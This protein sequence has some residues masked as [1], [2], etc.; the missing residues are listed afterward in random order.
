[1]SEIQ[2][3]GGIKM[4]AQEAAKRNEKAQGLRVWQVDDTW[5]YVESEDG[6][7]AY[8]CCITD[9]GDFCNCGDF[10]TRGKSDANFKCKHILAIM[11]SIPRNEIL[12]AQILE[13]RKPK[14]DER[15]I[16]QVEGKDFALYVGLLDLA[17]QK[18][19]TSMEV[20]L[21]QIPTKENEHTA[22]CRAVGKTVNGGSFIDVGD[23][24]P[25]N[26]NSKVAR[27]II[28]MASTR[29]KARCLRDLTNIGMT[30]LEELGDLTEVIGSEDME[31]RTYQS[32]RK[33]NVRKF[34]PKQTKVAQPGN[35]DG[36][37]QENENPVP[38][39]GKAEMA[40]QGDTHV[41]SPTEAPADKGE[42]ERAGAKPQ[43]AVAKPSAKETK[44]P[45]KAK[46]GNGNGK[47]KPEKIPMMSEAQ[48]SAIYNLSRR[49]GISVEELENMAQQTFTMPVE[50]L[51]HENAVSF[52]RTLQQ[53]A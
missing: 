40:V 9:K 36:R 48:K 33:D 31:E 18:N 24:N 27:H 13:K 29:A 53:A 23:A 37:K 35:G 25:N 5:F 4:T 45:I 10:A 50:N 12:E 6:K 15:F 52:I 17:H 49:R 34:A 42:A 3:K 30:C 44:T 14:L 16:K 19:L 2:S 7:I 1:L 43:T 51:T 26:C 11:N 38:N 39:Q 22:I 32:S 46:S 20:D 21:L 41:L 28:R 8:K 47:D